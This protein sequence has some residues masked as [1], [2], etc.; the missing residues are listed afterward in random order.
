MSVTSDDRLAAQVARELSLP[1][2][3]VH[4]GATLLIAT[5]VASPVLMA[6]ATGRHPV[7]VALAVYA[8][9]LIVVW[10]LAA[11]FGSALSVRPTSLVAEMHDETGAG[12]PTSPRPSP[13]EGASPSEE[14]ESVGSNGA[15]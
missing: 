7:P 6:G 14:N 13:S 4:F 2:P 15:H 11:L 5:L 8:A 1:E 3:G 10:F 12:E 9:V